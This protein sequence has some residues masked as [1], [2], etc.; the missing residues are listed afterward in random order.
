MKYNNKQFLTQLIFTLS[1]TAQLYAGTTGKIAGRATDAAT[2]E[3]MIGCNIIVQDIGLG[4]AS[5]IDG[6]YYII[7]VPPGIYD[8]KA[9]MIGYSTVNLTGVEVAS[10]FTTQANFELP[11]EVLKGQEVTVVAVKPLINRDLTAS[12]SVVSSAD[13]EALPVT[14]ISEALEL[15]A[16]FVDGHLRGGRSGEVSYWIDGVPMTDVYDGGTVVDVNKNAVE[17][18]Q[19]ISGA[20]NA[21]YGQAMS[22][23]V[24]I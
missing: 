22:G 3:P 2:G 12:T 16:G 21:E 9:V 13:F 11:T 23:I 17:E 18:M 20:F 24:N 19:L 6:N 7:N 15:Q 5:D 4:A 8:I 1:I 10:D 14:E